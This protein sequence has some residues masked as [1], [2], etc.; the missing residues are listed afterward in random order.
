MMRASVFLLG[1][2][3][4]TA[5][6]VPLV[7]FDG[8]AGTTHKFTELN[9]PVMGGQSTGTWTEADGV[10]TFDG[11]V[12]IVPTLKAPG[13]IEGWANDGHFADAS[14]AAGGA[15]VL[16][17]R[18]NTPNYEG[19]RVSFAAGALSPGFSCAA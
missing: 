2:G 18:S 4:A 1:A 12:N 11:Q 14:A 8:A 13:F 19:F 5:T 15:L 10:A 7:T 17:V 6:T 3:V 16:T 9:D